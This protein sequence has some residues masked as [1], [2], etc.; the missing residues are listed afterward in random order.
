MTTPE[1]ATQ[2]GGSKSCTQLMT[3]GQRDV[4]VSMGPVLLD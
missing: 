2:K 3:L 1:L 4:F